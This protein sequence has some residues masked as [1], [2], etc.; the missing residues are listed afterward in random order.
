MLTLSGKGVCN[1]V[2]IGKIHFFTH[3]SFDVKKQNAEDTQHEVLRYKSAVKTALAELDE[4]YE[5]GRRRV[6]E[7]EAEIFKIHAMMIEEDGDFS[8]NTI[9]IINEE[10]VRCEYAVSE[11]AKYF[12]GVFDAM[13]DEYMQARSADIKDVANRLLS[14]LGERK[15]I[16]ITEENTILVSDD[17]APSETI[18]LDKS[19]IAAFVTQN[20]SENSH[21]AILARSMNIPAIVNVGG[22]DE[23]IDGKRAVADGENGILYVEPDEHVMQE[24][25]SII[26]GMRQRV[27][28]LKKYIGV[29]AVTADGTKINL[30]ANIASPDD[31]KAA[32]ENGAEGV[33]LFRS[34]FLFL[35]R[36]APPDEEEHFAAYR[37]AAEEMNGKPVIVRTL[38]I[39]ADKRVEYLGLPKEENPAMGLRA[40]R[41]C[42]ENKTLFRTQLR[43]LYRASAFGE[44]AIM[45]PMITSA[46]E[47]Y[48]IKEI[49][50]SVKSGLVRDGCPIRKDTKLGIMI[51]TPAAAVISDILA[52]EVDFFSIGTNDLVSYTLA[53]DRQ[54]THLE[55]YVKNNH[56]AVL[57]LIEH[58]VKSAHKQGIWVGICGEAAADLSLTETF[59]KMG[60]DE[61]SVTPSAVLRIR[62]KI[63]SIGK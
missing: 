29:P 26:A 60:V 17:L 5:S 21:T 6:G 45:F 19:K 48:E 56:P 14:V 22:I 35:G 10:K 37:A 44:I 31:I 23:S 1:A 11:S 57:R 53:A 18:R 33:G 3:G 40:I 34:E 47:I 32:N 46:D 25:T 52:R 4:L 42:L 24:Y 54:N 27:T 51:E 63:C 58:T 30:Y 62:E 20:G 61:L 50:E 12:S 38:D 36:S 16:E 28:E 8:E 7:N 49:S 2:A 9:R 15:T 41:I 59:V 13:N 43:A 39:G 55:R